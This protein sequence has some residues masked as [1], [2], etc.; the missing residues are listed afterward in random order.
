MM[1]SNGDKTC[2]YYI[3]YTQLETEK[4]RLKLAVYSKIINITWYFY[5]RINS[6]LIT[7]YSTFRILSYTSHFIILVVGLIQ[8][9]FLI[10]LIL[11]KLELFIPKKYIY[12]LGL[13]L[14]LVEPD[15]HDLEAMTEIEEDI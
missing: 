3:A 12:R 8:F 6:I 4:H 2:D 9:P 5:Q 14:D 13:Y 7:I 11:I 15:Y 1:D 10:P